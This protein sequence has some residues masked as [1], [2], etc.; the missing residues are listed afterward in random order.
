MQRR[1]NTTV[2]VVGCTT[3]WGAPRQWIR[4]LLAGVGI[5]VWAVTPIGVG[6][7][8]G[9]TLRSD[10]ADGVVSSI[11]L[12]RKSV[13]DPTST[14]VGLLAWTY[15]ALNLVHVR[16]APSFIRQE[17]L[18]KE[19][20]CLDPFLLSESERLLDRYGFLSQAE[21]T[22]EADGNGGRDVVV[23]T[24]DEWST[25]V[26]VGGTYDGGPNLERLQVT[27][28]NFLGRGVFAEFTYRARR[29]VKSQSFGLATPRFL[30]R[31]DAGIAWGSDRPG[32][33]FDQYVRYPFVG[34][35][36]RYA[37]RQG[38]SRSTRYFSYSTDGS[39][40]FS[41]VLVPAY[42][43]VVELS[44]ARRFGQPGRALIAG[45]S[46]TRDVVD[47]PRTPQIA[48][49]SE[50]DELEPWTGPLPARMH[51]QLVSA[52][53]T[54][55]GLQVG[56]RRF[57]YAEYVG[58]DGVRDR[59]IVSLGLFAGVTV[60]R[61]FDLFAPSGVNGLSDAFGRVHASFGVP[62]GSS[63]L[64]G[65]ATLETRRDEGAWRDILADADL[66]AY[67]RNR[68]FESH[69]FFLRASAGGGWATALPY[70]LSLGGREGVRSLVED[71]FPGGRMVRF[72]IEDRIVLPWPPPTDVDLGLTVFSDIGRVW[73]GDVPFG[74]DSGWKAG[75]GF[76]LRIGFPPRT[77]NVWRTD[78]VFPVGG[79]GGDPIFRVTFELNRLRAGFFTPDVLRS[80]RLNLGPDHF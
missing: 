10:C 51:R 7:Q 8:V 44:A 79:G 42:R 21:I 77:R 50:F 69:T 75:V 31:T 24:R 17:L 41:Q 80:R 59:Q 35:T 13:F 62:V 76:G 63:L 4:A 32:D 71:R 16:T 46:V 67:L 38:F 34:E 78:I 22:H 15:K 29:E 47:F 61:G 9:S 68:R 66:V 70:Q 26:D 28:E 2:F 48:Y 39:E 6:A 49:G 12:D 3:A 18:F 64:H 72:V 30:G 52:A 73:P 37:I 33:H 36:G 27:E 58:L 1:S 54:R 11:R 14:N 57:H 53:T 74:V 5:A 56:T 45:V 23:S 55:V 43:E 20:D 25:K 65:G 19:G 60:G 40:P